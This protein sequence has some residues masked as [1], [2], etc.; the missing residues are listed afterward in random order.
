MG[1]AGSRPVAFPGDNS[2]GTSCRGLVCACACSASILPLIPPSSSPRTRCRL[3]QGYHCLANRFLLTR[4]LF[5]NVCLPASALLQPPPQ[6]PARPP[7]RPAMSLSYAGW[8][9]DPRGVRAGAPNPLTQS[10]LT[11][12]VLG[13]EFPVSVVVFVLELMLVATDQ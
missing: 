8:L 9:H 1:F 13:L 5:R 6:K 4:S 2:T 11:L 7:C 12:I 3:H 10:V